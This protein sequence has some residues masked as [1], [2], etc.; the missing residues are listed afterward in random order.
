MNLD[1]NSI[2][3]HYNKIIQDSVIDLS[4]ISFVHPWAIA[5]CCLNIIKKHR[6]PD[7]RL[8]LPKNIDALR[9][10]KR[11]HF[12]EFLIEMGYDEAA[13][14]LRNIQI[15][16][17]D[18]LNIQEITRCRYRDEL[19]AR[20]GRFIAMFENFGLNDNEARLTTALLGELGNNVFD[21][22][23]GNW[24]TDISGC[25]I[26]AQNFPQM[27]RIE[28]VVC[29]PG[30]GFKGS[31]IVR[32][33]EL[34]DDIE[35]IKKGLAGNTS[36]INEERGNGLKFIQQ[37]TIGKFSGNLTIHS[38]AGLVEVSERGI[39]EKIVPKILGTIVQIMLY[40]K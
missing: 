14:K 15:T 12:D 31:L 13:K 29:D 39:T 27:K 19:D 33:P 9:Y 36:R 35:A 4:E 17:K 6:L 28:F 40:Y 3:K 2:C 22:N 23:S 25:I 34:K 32:F 1:I 37:F 21:H 11:I 30:I 10:L 24:P 18:N 5:F 8:T 7:K 20:L 38:G 26:V 16:E